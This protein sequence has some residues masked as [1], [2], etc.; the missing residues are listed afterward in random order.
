PHP[1]GTMLLQAGKVREEDLHRAR[2]MQKAGDERRLGDVLVAIGA[3]SQRELQRQVRAQ[4]EAVVFELMSWSEGY[5]SFEEG[6]PSEKF[7]EVDVRIPVE[8]VLMEGARRIDEWSQIQTRIPH[9]GIVPKLSAADGGSLD[10]HP[11]EWSILA[12]IDG[13]R[14]VREVALA[15]GRAEFDVAK[16]LF[17][18]AAAGVVGL[19]HPHRPTAATGGRELAILIARTEDRLAEGDAQGALLA[20]QEVMFTHP[21]EPMTHLVLGRALL[22][23]GRAPEAADA[24]RRVLQYD[25]GSAAGQRYLGTA[26]AVGG[27]FHDAADQLLRWSRISDMPPEEQALEPQVEQARAAAVALDEALKLLR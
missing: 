5:F 22:G 12:V 20:A 15:I 7:A 17:G 19:E 9:L 6:A 14:D 10:L 25:P 23:L 4:V 26:L 11:D 2:D 13:E 24:F 18:L 8:A 16:T 21:L 27:R 3:V 1:L